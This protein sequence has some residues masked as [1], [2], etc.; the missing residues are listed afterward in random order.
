MDKPITPRLHGALDYGFLGVLLGG[1]AVLKLPRNVRLVFAAMGAV[2][3][4]LNSLTD[5]PY[6]VDRV[7]PFRVHGLIE[8][9]S[10]PLYVGLPLAVG[11]WRDRNSRLFFLAAGASLVTVYNLTDWQATNTDA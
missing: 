6:A 4:T 10:A 9:F 1:P 2:Q 7:V 3:T 8:K 11:A 5:Q